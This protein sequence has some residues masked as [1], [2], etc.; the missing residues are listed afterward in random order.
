MKIAC[1]IYKSFSVAVVNTMTKV[2]YRIRSLFEFTVSEGH[3]EGPC[4][5]TKKWASTNLESLG[6][7]TSDCSK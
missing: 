4:E 3:A 6:D 5:D 2:S 1:W 7:R